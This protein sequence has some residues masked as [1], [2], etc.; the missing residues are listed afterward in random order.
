ML[1][2]F[3]CRSP[4]SPERR[5]AGRIGLLTLA[6]FA[7]RPVD[8]AH[9]LDKQGSAHA[10]EVS[11]E[12]D[13]GFDIEGAAMLGVSLI[14]KSYAARP[15]N[16]GLALM[17]YG[18]HA[19]VDLIGR[20]LSIPIDLNAFS[21][22][23]RKGFGV[24]APT[25]FDVITGVTTTHSLVT[26]VDGEL[27]ARIEHDMPVDR[28]GFTQTY[29]DVRARALYSLAQVS[30]ALKRDLIDGDV[31]GHVMLGWFA[32]NPSYAARPDNTG[33]ALFRYGG[34]TE[35]SVWHD[36]LSLGFDAT[37]FTD[38][39]VN[40]LRPS[41]LDATYE[42]IGRVGHYE[43]HLAYERDMPID[44]GGFVQDF[45]YALV[46]Y[47]F[48]LIHDAPKPMEGRGSIISP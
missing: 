2:A 47:D 39:R 10:G 45:V 36:H 40:A 41:E 1:A 5:C 27:G 18:L 20:K 29:A 8:D 16:T 26:G 43:I 6:F 3:R 38:R 42:I 44:R 35:L 9:A 14:N 32:L 15:D 37:M 25:E 7:V 22:R 46:M 12:D 24:F 17:R 11:K 33:N 48:D 30:P 34:H 21:D 13:G 4:S 28:G 31:S 23:Q 19:D